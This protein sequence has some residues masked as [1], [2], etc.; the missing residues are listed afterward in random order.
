MH[1]LL[2]EQLEMP[3]KML[4]AKICLR[5]TLSEK[6]F[7]NLYIPKHIISYHKELTKNIAFLP[8]PILCLKNSKIC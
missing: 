5:E 1:F 7:Q 2:V 8:K 4:F 6:S 3:T